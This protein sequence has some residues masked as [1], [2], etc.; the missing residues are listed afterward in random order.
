MDI[1][2]VSIA[3]FILIAMIFLISFL[4]KSI[5]NK[6]FIADDGSVFEN[7]SDLD[8]YQ[9]LY[10]KTKTLFSVVEDNPS[11]EEFL[12]FEPSFIA[13]IKTEGFK[14]FKTIVKYRIQLKK[15]SDLINT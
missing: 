4:F 1:T 10:K 11:R 6:S 5:N 2:L 12:D 13:K 9:N 8:V 3:F 14:D 7:Q 15:L